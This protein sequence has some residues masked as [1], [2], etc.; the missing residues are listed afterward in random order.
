[1]NNP[2]HTNLVHRPWRRAICASWFVALLLALPGAVQGQFTYTNNNGAI[3]I[4]GY[5]GSFAAMDIPNTIDGLPVT[6][7]G[8]G[9]FAG[10]LSLT[11]VTIPDSVTSIGN[12]AFDNCW[13]LTNVTIPNSVTNIGDGAFDSCYR[14][15]SVT[16][17][18]SVTSIADEAFGYCASLMSVTI[19]NSIT[20]IGDGAFGGCSSVTNV[21]IPNSV[22]SI[23]NYAFQ[24]CTRLTNIIIPNSVTHI[25]DW[26]FQSTG[27]T[28]AT[29]PNGVTSIGNGAF[30]D[31]SSVTNVT[32]GDSVTNIGNQAFYDCSSLTS[33]TI[34]NSVTSVGYYAFSGCTSLTNVRIGDS[35]T[36]IGDGSF[37]DCSSLT[38]IWVDALN[39]A[40]SSSD[41]VLFN[42]SQTT[43]IQYPP[44]K[45]ASSYTIPNSVTSIGDGAFNCCTDLTGVTIPNSVTSVEDYAFLGCTSLT[46]VRIGDSV[47]SIG[48][49]AFYDCSSLTGV[50]IPNSVTN[51]AHEAFG[52]CTSMTAI[53]FRG[54][55]PSLGDGVF[56]QDQ[57]TIYYLPGTTGWGT[58]FGGLPTVLWWTPPSIQASPLTQTAEAGSAVGLQVRASGALPLFYLWYFN[59]TNLIT[60]STNRELELTNLQFSQS[61]TYTL[62]VSNALGVDTSSPALLNVIAPVERTPVPGVKV[63]GEAGSLLNVDYADSVSPAPTWTPLGS[64]SLTVTPQYYFDLAL[65]L[66]PQ[67]F[68]RAWQTGA[69]SVMPSLDLHMIPAITL[70]GTI[71]GS[72][73]LDYINQF[74]PIDAWATLDTVV[75]TNT[76]QL[77]F[78]VAAPGQTPRLYRVVPLP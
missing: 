15:A 40:Y 12:V 48:D 49:E 19:P 72:V 35:V 13:S 38:A 27:L 73:R 43:L 71:G 51:I 41:S 59:N 61:G 57:A 45:A 66:P 8:D 55:A 78:D 44:A 26:A 70:T 54:N 37:G 36:S 42:K 76:S 3:T 60:C 21:L 4:T 52:W 1:M 20:S 34:P 29:I 56:D 28:R 58:T 64:V 16:I 67:R 11:G 46:N 69:P 47:T 30:G 14:L 18:N 39:P 33:V 5:T 31:C 65:P 74:G 25:G 2:H 32:I 7:I 24:N 62:V 6:S 53:Y 63:V 10:C 77:Y 22:T 75:L 50:T 17:P 9:A 23:G 68:Y